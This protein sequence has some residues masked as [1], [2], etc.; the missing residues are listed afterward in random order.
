MKCTLEGGNA[1]IVAKAIQSLSKVGKELFIEA[2]IHGLRMRSINPTQ[3]AVASICF[4]RCMFDTFQLPPSGDCCCKIAMKPCLGVFRNMK[5]VEHCELSIVCNRTKFQVN[6]RCKLE[7]TKQAL[8]AIVDELNI[9]S[10]VP[11]DRSSNIIRGDHKLLM[12][13]SNSFN[14]SEEELTLEATPDSLSAKNYIEGA[15]VN[16]KFMRS[17]LKLKPSEFDHYQV[18]EGAVI[19]F[20]IKEFRAFLLFAEAL[21][22]QL[23]LE[24][25]DAGSP[26]F[27]KIKKHREIECLLILST[28]SPDDVSFSE[29]YRPREISMCNSTNVAQKRKSSGPGQDVQQKRRLAEDTTLSDVD[30]ALFQFREHRPERPSEAPSVQPA[31]LLADGDTVDLVEEEADEE[32]LLLAVS[33]AMEASQIPPPGSTEVCFYNT[34]DAPPTLIPS[35]ME[36]NDDEEDESIPQS[37][38]R[39]REQR[40]RTIFSRCFQNTYV[41]REPSPNSQV[42]APNS[43]TED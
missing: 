9:T 34:E 16:D 1:R 37:P 12:E 11:T 31:R 13:I 40:V 32:A 6:L 20:C 24:F 39:E 36:H 15:R 35:Q 2:D 8:I 29:D 10:D 7:T 4:H 43:D 41:P 26:F 5:Q 23:T 30:T 28:L 38:E 25:E 33:D 18:A 21:N 19:T 27:V 42:Y 3:S 22:A 14:S 17:Q